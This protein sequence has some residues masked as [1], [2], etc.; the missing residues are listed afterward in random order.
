MMVINANA[1]VSKLHG[2]RLPQEDHTGL[3][4]APDNR[5]VCSSDVILQ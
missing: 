1:T 3:R 5:R 4:Q 2:M